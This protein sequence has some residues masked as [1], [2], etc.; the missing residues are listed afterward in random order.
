[1]HD[2]CREH[3]VAAWCGGMLETGLG[4]AANLALAALPG[5]TLPGDLSASDRYFARDLTAPFVLDDG[6]LAVPTAPGIGVD[7]RPRR[8]A[9]LHHVG[10]GDRRATAL[11]AAPRQSV[12]PHAADVA[13]RM[14]RRR[15]V[16]G[17]ADI[18]HPVDRVAERAGREAVAHLA[19]VARR[20]RRDPRRRA[21]TR[22]FAIAWRDTGMRPRAPTRSSAP[23]RA[24]ATTSRRVGS[25]SAAN[26]ASSRGR[27]PARVQARG[28]T[29]AVVDG[30]RRGEPRRTPIPVGTEPHLARV[31]RML[32]PSARR[33]R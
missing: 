15:V 20:S 27:A 23:V 4:R 18:G 14:R 21:T 28:G 17:R 6:R 9:R 13:A 2:V 24:R 11:T 16:P 7:A 12:E 3:G 25:A 30:A 1:M 32:P 5:F 8:A 10:R 29:G 19:P 22:C 31:R 33:R 26:T